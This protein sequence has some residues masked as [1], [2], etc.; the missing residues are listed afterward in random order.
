MHGKEPHSTLMQWLI[1]RI[2]FLFKSSVNTCLDP[3]DLFKN[4]EHFLNILCCSS[5]WL[6]MGYDKSFVISHQI[7]CSLVKAFYK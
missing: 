6:S 4:Q 7:S 2:T 3:V 5:L 1:L